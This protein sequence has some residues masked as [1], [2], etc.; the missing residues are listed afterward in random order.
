[1]DLLTRKPA[2]ARP[3]AMI[4]SAPERNRQAFFALVSRT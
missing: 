2:A 1:M 4:D 3:R